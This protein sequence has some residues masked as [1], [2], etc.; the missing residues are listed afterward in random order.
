MEE[1]ALVNEI[2]VIRRDSRSKNRAMEEDHLAL[3]TEETMA[4]PDHLV[5]MIYLNMYLCMYACMYVCMYIST[6]QKAVMSRRKP[7][8]STPPTSLRVLCILMSW[9][10]TECMYMCSNS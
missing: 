7:C 3:Y 8:A 6:I 1:N 2:L 9:L 5:A 10:A 4:D